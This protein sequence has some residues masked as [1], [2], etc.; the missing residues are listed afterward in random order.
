MT[1]LLKSICTR[2]DR[3]VENDKGSKKCPLLRFTTLAQTGQ[4]RELE[5]NGPLLVRGVYT[6]RKLVD[7]RHRF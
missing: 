3:I 7:W 6:D 1:I 4:K 5:K 2:M